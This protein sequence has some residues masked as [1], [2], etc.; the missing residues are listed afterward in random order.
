VTE[1]ACHLLTAGGMTPT[2]AST[3]RE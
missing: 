3:L 2:V 1:S